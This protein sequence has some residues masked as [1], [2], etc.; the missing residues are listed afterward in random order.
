VMPNISSIIL[1]RRN[2]FLKPLPYAVKI[3]ICVF[4]LSC[5]H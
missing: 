2:E 5:V 3:F 4:R 1:G